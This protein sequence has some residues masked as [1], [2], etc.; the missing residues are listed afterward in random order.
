[1]A[2]PALTSR[3]GLPA[4]AENARRISGRA[5]RLELEGRLRE[6]VQTWTAIPGEYA[7]RI[8][9]EEIAAVEAELRALGAPRSSRGGSGTCSG[10]WWGCTGR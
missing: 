9:R 5:R 10:S 3:G 8:A 1:M 7:K 2:S 6:L 4:V